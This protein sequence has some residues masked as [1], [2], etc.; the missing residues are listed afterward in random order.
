VAPLLADGQDLSARV[1]RLLC[2]AEAEPRQERHMPIFA[3]GGMVVVAAAIGIGLEP[4][5]YHSVHRLLE[6]LVR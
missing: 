2:L 1:D 6:Y 4:A 5:T 3:V